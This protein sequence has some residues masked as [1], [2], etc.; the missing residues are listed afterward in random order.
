MT[1]DIG[2]CEQ[3]IPA[4]NELQ[5]KGPYKYITFGI[6]R[7]GTEIIVLKKATEGTYDDFLWEFPDEECKYGVYSFE[8]ELEKPINNTIFIHWNPE[9]ADHE[10]R[11]MYADN[12]VVLHRE[13]M[14]LGT[15]LNGIHKSEIS[16]TKAIEKLQL[17]A[18]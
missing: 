2:L 11:K 4:F 9:D 5:P 12:R 6:D 8:G 1:K 16:R 17:R 14:G 13:L 10:R 3:C 15:H 7:E 18:R